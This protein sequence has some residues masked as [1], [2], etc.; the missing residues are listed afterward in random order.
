MLSQDDR[1]ELE[2]IAHQFELEDPLFARAL[3]EGRADRRWPLQLAIVVAVAVFLAGL[4]AQAVPVML[5]GM[6][7]C[8]IAATGYLWQVTRSQGPPSPGRE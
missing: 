6:A 7:A 3:S 4:I 5:A 8:G 2:E 1:R